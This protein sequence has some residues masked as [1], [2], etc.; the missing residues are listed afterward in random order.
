MQNRPT[1]P[2]YTVA[3]LGGAMLWIGVSI[4]SGRTEA[5]D[6]PLYWSLAYPLCILLAGV[7]GYA[8]PERPWRWA[9][10]VML[11][12]PVI[13]AF[14]GSGFG[15]LPLGLILFAFLSLPAIG[16]AMIAARLAR[17]RART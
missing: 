13:L 5:W 15:L 10:V 16:V 1:T 12:Q 14:S 17:R 7:L 3:I 4:V 2:A 9:L 6:L 8:Y 11:V